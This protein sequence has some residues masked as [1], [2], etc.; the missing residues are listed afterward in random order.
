MKREPQYVPLSQRSRE[1]WAA[2]A[3]KLDLSPEVVWEIYVSRF[4]TGVCAR[5][6]H[7]LVA[8]GRMTRAEVLKGTTIE[9]IEAVISAKPKGETVEDEDF[10]AGDR[11]NFDAKGVLEIGDEWE[12]DE[13]KRYLSGGEYITEGKAVRN[14]RLPGRRVRLLHDRHQN[15]LP[16]A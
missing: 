2:T 7:S 12:A 3:A 10:D 15:Q 1:A 11:L 13:T 6:F 9:K 8:S 5:N 4:F 16:S 14:H